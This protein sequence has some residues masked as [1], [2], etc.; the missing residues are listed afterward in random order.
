[1]E[2]GRF[3]V[4]IPDIN[5]FGGRIIRRIDRKMAA[6]EMD[7][8]TAS[9]EIKLLNGI[10]DALRKLQALREG[11]PDERAGSEIGKYAQ[12]F[13]LAARRRANHAGTGVD[14]QRADY[15]PDA[16]DSA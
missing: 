6:I 11:G 4:A 3:K 14:S 16:P 8:Y 9:D 2:P 10:L 1:M 5:D 7:E 12:T 13:D 15:D